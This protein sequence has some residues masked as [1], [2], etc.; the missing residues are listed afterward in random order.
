MVIVFVICWIFWFILRLIFFLV[1][2]GWIDFKDL[3][4]IENVFYV[5]III[6]YFSFVINFLLY[7][8][9]K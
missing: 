4:Y 9:F 5:F 6:R 7:M 2:V 3:V 1:N 8:F